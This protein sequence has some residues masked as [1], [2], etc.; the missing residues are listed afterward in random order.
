MRRLAFAV[1]AA[2]TFACGEAAPTSPTDAGVDAPP[3]VPLSAL[4]SIDEVAGY[5]TVK[6]DVVKDGAAVAGKYNAP[7]LTSKAGIFRV[8]Y[9]LDPKKKFRQ[10]TIEAELHLVTDGDNVLKEAKTIIAAS[11]EDSYPS[12][13]NFSF[14]DTMLTTATS[15][16]VVLRD[17][18]LAAQGTDVAEVRYPAEGT[19]PI[20]VSANPGTVRVVIVPIQYGADQSGRLPDTGATQLAAMNAYLLDM[21]PVN[22]VSLTVRSTP[23][24]W[25]SAVDANGNGWGELLDAIVQLRAQDK[26]PSG[27]YY[28][29]AFQPKDT[30][31]SFCNGGCVLG[32]AANVTGAFDV[33]ERAVISVGYN[34]NQFNET[35]A[36]ELGHV[37]GR[38]HSPCGGAQGT[39][40]KYPY[41][42]GAS[43]VSG[44]RI[45][46]AA[47]IPGG[48]LDLMGYCQPEWI[49]DDTYQALFD[50]VKIVNGAAVNCTIPTQSYERILIGE[51]G[52]VVRR[53]TMVR[54]EPGGEVRD[55]SATF[56]DGTKRTIHGHWVAFDHVDGGFLYVLS[57]SVGDVT[58][59]AKP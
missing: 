28:V 55:V 34:G 29:G 13:F 36:H 35:V 47:L 2:A 10:R 26:P 30:F 6:V 57:K 38:F 23:L 3:P 24:V 44:Y 12:T 40:P 50:R 49:S 46:Q 58:R 54:E 31:S 45:S 20:T 17:P 48:T 25:G 39:D 33:S 9:K 52:V 27:T 14:D 43:G 53:S 16:Y 32:L 37:H 4:L 5:Q 8:F 56:A 51:G 22:K 7:L 42:G 1:L 19:Q 59:I 21:Y 41:A 15:F 11:N 18:A